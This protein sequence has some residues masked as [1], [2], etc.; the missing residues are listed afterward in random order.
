MAFLLVV[1]GVLFS[2]ITVLSGRAK[3]ARKIVMER[4]AETLGT[5]EEVFERI[6]P[7]EMSPEAHELSAVTVLFG[8]DSAPRLEEEELPHPGRPMVQRFRQFKAQSSNWLTAQLT[9]TQSPVDPPPEFVNAFLSEFSEPIDRVQEILLADTLPVWKSDLTKLHSA[10]IPN[11]RGHIDLNKLLL[12]ECFSALHAGELERA[13][14]ALEAAWGL[15]GMLEDGP[16]LITQIVR[17]NLLSTQAAAVR[18]LPWLDHWL[19][20]L[21]TEL[22][23]KDVEA[24]LLYE[25]WIWPQINFSSNDSANVVDRVKDGILGPYMRL[26]SADASE[27]WRRT[28]LRLKETQSWCGPALER[29]GIRLD[30]PVPWWNQFGKMLIMDIEETIHRVALTQLQ[31]ELSRKLLEMEVSRRETGAWPVESEPWLRSRVCPMDR[32]VYSVEGS[33]ASLRLDREIEKSRG[34]LA[35]WEFS[36]DGR[37]DDQLR[38]N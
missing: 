25:G 2:S 10:P 17:L 3:G 6:P 27:R 34:I 11:L 12:S 14:R 38:K 1:L 31:L 20:R 24:A 19:P 8:V 30:I 18:R 37:A 33:V 29:M 22:L 23:R 16:E 15:T 7:R 13:E 35:V 5:P 26:G 9:G 21:N 4:W 32:W 28:I 36:L